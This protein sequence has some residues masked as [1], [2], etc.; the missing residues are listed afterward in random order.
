MTRVLSNLSVRWHE[1][2]SQVTCIWLIAAADAAADAAAVA[3]AH[4]GD[5]GRPPLALVAAGPR[6]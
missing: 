1:A 4:A 6:C 5:E 2:C 3:A